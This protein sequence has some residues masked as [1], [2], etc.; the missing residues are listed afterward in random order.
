MSRKK[1]LCHLLNYSHRY[2]EISFELV[3][4]AP[5][6][7]SQVVEQKG[8]WTRVGVKSMASEPQITREG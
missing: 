1:G 3:V 4:I 5:L 2:D 7:T 6:R 8:R